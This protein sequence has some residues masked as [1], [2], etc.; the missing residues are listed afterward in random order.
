MDLEQTANP[1]V[2]MVVTAGKGWLFCRQRTVSD[3]ER[4]IR[5]GHARFFYSPLGLP[6]LP[7]IPFHSSACLQQQLRYPPLHNRTYPFYPRRSLP[8]ARR[9]IRALH[10]QRR[11]ATLSLI[12]VFLAP[13]LSLLPE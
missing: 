5:D 2:V 3:A 7:S 9:Q 6:E 11:G 13:A 1:E 10:Q 8:P 4:E 12:R